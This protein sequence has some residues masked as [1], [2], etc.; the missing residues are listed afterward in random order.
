MIPVRKL[1]HSRTFLALAG[2][3]L[4]LDAGAAGAQSPARPMVLTGG[5]TYRAPALPERPRDSFRIELLKPGLLALDLSESHLIAIE[6]A[7]EVVT[8]RPGS[9]IVWVAQPGWLEISLTS[10]VPGQ[11]LGAYRLRNSFVAKVEPVMED[12]DL[13]EDPPYSCSLLPAPLGDPWTGSG[14]VVVSESVDEWD[15]DV[16]EGDT[17][18]AGVLRLES[19]LGDLQ[20]SLFGGT[21]CGSDTLLGA[22]ALTGLS[23]VLAPVFP[24]PFRIAIDAA[25]G[26]A[27]PYRL[28]AA[29]LDPCRQGELDDHHET[30]LCATPLTGGHARV[31]GS[32]QGDDVDQ[33]TFVLGQPG[34]VVLDLGP[35]GGGWRLRV[36]DAAGQP[37]PGTT[38]SAGW[39]AALGRGRY[40]LAVDRPDGSAADYGLS[41]SVFR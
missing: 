25:L 29:L 39:K 38:G 1:R 15:C 26:F 9:T 24:G 12:I 31:P 37:V 4:W 13:L 20:A 35:A 14:G 34:E 36:T 2:T 41:L 17:L 32:A 40:F 27:G 23:Q 5:A 33:F 16:L 22:G 8:S 21:V 10:G 18:A 7:Q 11:R 28:A 3:V 19:R 30:W 6:P